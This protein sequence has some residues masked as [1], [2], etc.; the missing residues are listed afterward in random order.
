M[1]PDTDD[2]SAETLDPSAEEAAAAAARLEG[3]RNRRQV[4]SD[5]PLTPNMQGCLLL[6]AV[7]GLSGADEVVLQRYFR[8]FHVSF[9]A[10]TSLVS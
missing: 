8:P 1:A 2:L 9:I 10:H 3:W 4:K 5:D 6:Q 7:V